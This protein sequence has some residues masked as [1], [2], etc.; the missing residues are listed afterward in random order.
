MDS[1]NTYSFEQLLLDDEMISAMR[2]VLSGVQLN[3][4]EEEFPLVCESGWSG[5]YLTVGRTLKHYRI[6]WRPSLMT[7]TDFDSYMASGE[8]LERR[9]KKRITELLSDA[10]PSVLSSDIDQEL[11]EVLTKRGITL[12]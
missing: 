8:S 5:N 11:K 9:C 1:V 6:F 10:P 4:L 7:R 3:M 12:P 2:R